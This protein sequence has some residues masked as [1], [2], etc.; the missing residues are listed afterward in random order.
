MIGYCNWSFL[1]LLSTGHG[2]EKR[3]GLVI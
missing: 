1:D 2:F 3:Y